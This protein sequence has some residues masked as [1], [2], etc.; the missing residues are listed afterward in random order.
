[1]ARRLFK[2]WFIDFDPVHAKAALRRE[3]PKLSNADLSRRALPN[4][5]PEIAEPFPDS[6]EDATLGA[7]PEGWK[8]SAIGDMVTAVGGATPS[9]T[10]PSFWDGDTPFAT[11]KD[12]AGLAS[13]VLLS[14][15]RRIT[16]AGVERISSGVLP[17]GTVLLSSRAPIGYLAIA[18]IPVAVNQGFVAMI[19]DR[20]VPNHYILHWAKENLETIV[21]HANGTTFPE[22]SKKNFRPIAAIA[23]DES[24][25]KQFQ[26]IAGEFHRQLVTNVRESLRL[27]TVRDKLLPRLLSGE[28][29]VESSMEVYDA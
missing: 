4:M 6:F 27:A 29:S 14:T 19:C 12:L 2:S 9:T 21:G 17:T 5:A 18:E 11:P 7:I 22:I 3:H 25:T 10:E 26:S 1:M 16:Q 20:G 23:P 15:E 13:P 28:L 24:I 8:V